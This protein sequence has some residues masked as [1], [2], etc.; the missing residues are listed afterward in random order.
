MEIQTSN[1]VVNLI[2]A[3]TGPVK[4]AWSC[5][6]PKTLLTP[7]HWEMYRVLINYDVLAHKLASN[8]DLLKLKDISKCSSWHAC[9][10][11]NAALEMASK[12]KKG[13]RCTLHSLDLHKSKALWWVTVD[14][15]FLDWVVLTH[16]WSSIDLSQKLHVSFDLLLYGVWIDFGTRQNAPHH[17]QKAERH[18]KAANRT[19]ASV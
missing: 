2:I 14:C 12:V 3:S 18:P 16:T 5:H 15:M 4:Q 1:L 9:G 19:S 8:V 17:K 7:I 13:K 6:V 10:R 11:S